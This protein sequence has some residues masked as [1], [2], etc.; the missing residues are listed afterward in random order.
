MGVG[1][2]PLRKRPKQVCAPPSIPQRLPSA[3]CSLC[4][5]ASLHRLQ[6]VMLRCQRPQALL[7]RATDTEN[8]GDQLGRGGEDAGAQDTRKRLAKELNGMGL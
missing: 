7:D 4:L 8:I 1:P 6:W 5:S 3:C 2:C